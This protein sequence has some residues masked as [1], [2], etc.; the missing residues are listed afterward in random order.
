MEMSENDA[1]IPCE[2]E[3]GD[4]ESITIK[5]DSNIFTLN[6]L[7]NENSLSI[8]VFENDNSKYDSYSKTM[9]LNEIKEYHKIFSGINSFDE[10]IDYLKT[11]VDNKK[12]T[13]KKEDDRLILILSTEYLFQH[14]LIEIPLLLNNINSKYL[15]NNLSKE[16]KLMK[17]KI[18]YLENNI[19]KNINETIES[20]KKE[21]QNLK[22]ENKILNEKL[23]NQNEEIKE[24]KE[25]IK[26]M[27]KNKCIQEELIFK[28]IYKNSSII[29]EK[30]FEIIYEAL[31]KRI[32][33][34]IIKIKKLYQASID[35][36]DPINFHSKCDNIPNTLILFKSA[37]KRRFGGFTSATWESNKGLDKED[38]YSFLFSLD[39]QKI[40]P[41]KNEGKTI[42]CYKNRGP[43]FGNGYTI[44]V[45]GNPIKE[46]KLYTN[47]SSPETNFDFQD[48]KNALSEDGK[49]EHIFAEDYEVFQIIF[50]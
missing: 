48:D 1:P 25:I 11:L 16:I 49:K 43:I 42:S 33:K 40:Y 17:E 39:K 26:L 21:I 45:A 31:Q 46:K 3:K 37:G 19:N 10:F 35:G 41:Y 28:S 14:H 50:E 18:N 27:Y 7:I 2:T 32:K 23:L 4:S 6:I 15:S 8:N 30:E 20:Q 44:K 22:E 38:K 9:T 5:Q 29:K 47:E 24:I 13:F 12:L 36:G 34:D